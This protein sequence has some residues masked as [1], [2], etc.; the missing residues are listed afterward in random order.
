[1]VSENNDYIASSGHMEVPLSEIINGKYSWTEEIPN[2]GIVRFTY[3]FN[4]NM[5]N[6]EY[7]TCDNPQ[8]TKLWS[9]R[10]ESTKNNSLYFY[11][12]F[13]IGK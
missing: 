3:N 9:Q 8:I 1:M 10:K 5:L 11:N 4:L 7:F 12:G 13:L 6:D 2:I